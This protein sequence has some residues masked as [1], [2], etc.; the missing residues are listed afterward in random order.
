MTGACRTATASRSSQTIRSALSR[1]WASKLHW[2]NVLLGKGHGQAKPIE[3]TFGKGGL[4]QYIDIA[5]FGWLL[6]Q[7]QSHGKPDNY[8]ERVANAGLSAH[9]CRGV[10][11]CNAKLGRQT[12]PAGAS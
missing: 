4:E 10:A 8:G 1:S 2:S 6:H 9:G 11:M 7:P 3:R 5:R 12:K